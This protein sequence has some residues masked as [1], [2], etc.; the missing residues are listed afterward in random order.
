MSDVHLISRIDAAKKIRQHWL[1][2][3]S[4]EQLLTAHEP[5]WERLRNYEFE[6]DLAK[7]FGRASGASASGARSTAFTARGRTHAP[8]S[9]IEETAKGFERDAE[10]LRANGFA[11]DR[12]AAYVRHRGKTSPCVGCGVGVWGDA[13]GRCEKCRIEPTRKS[14]DG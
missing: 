3:Y 14:D 13:P 8:D 7:A 12:L 6:S 2:T 5:N 10:E 1:D 4:K 11:P 9:V